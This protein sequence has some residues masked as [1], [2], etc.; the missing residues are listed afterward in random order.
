MLPSILSARRHL[1]Q[2]DQSRASLS[3]PPDS[4][5]TGSSHGTA[6]PR[7]R[8]PSVRSS[9]KRES[10]LSRV[11]SFR[12]SVASPRPPSPPRVE[13]PYSS[14]T[15]SSVTVSTPPLEHQNALVRIG[16]SQQSFSTVSD[17]TVLATPQQ[18]LP[19]PEASPKSSARRKSIISRIFSIRSS[20]R[21]P[22]RSG[23]ESTHVH[24]I[25][26][27]H[28]SHRSS[29]PKPAPRREPTPEV[30]LPTVRVVR[31]KLKRVPKKSPKASVP[32]VIPSRNQH[33]RV[34]LVEP[35][36]S[37]RSQP[38]IVRPS[39]RQQQ[40][41][42]WVQSPP[43]PK[44]HSQPQPKLYPQPQPKLRP[45]PQPQVWPQPEPQ[46]RQ[47][48][49]WEQVPAKPKVRPQPQPLQQPPIQSQKDS[50]Q[51][52]QSNEHYAALRAQ[53]NAA[54]DA[55]GRS[56]D[57]SKQAFQRGDGAMA[58]QLSEEGKAHRAEMERL[59]AEAGAW[60]YGEN[61]K[62]LPP[63]TVDLHGLYVKEAVEYTERAL[64]K[65]REKGATYLRVIVG[66]GIHSTVQ[67]PKIK[68]AIEELMRNQGIEAEFD[69]LN[70][71]VLVVYPEGKDRM[72]QA[73]NSNHS[74]HKPAASRVDTKRRK[75]QT[76]AKARHR[77]SLRRSLYRIS[78]P[79]RPRNTFT[80]PSKHSHSTT[81][82]TR[83]SQPYAKAVQ[84]SD[85]GHPGRPNGNVSYAQRVRA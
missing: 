9:R 12:R 48:P 5:R 17:H 65:A 8:Q 82:N 73:I 43:K 54:G 29:T 46:L 41:N 31:P 64:E 6:R 18:P 14:E 42:A 85:A 40:P 57:A 68:P 76:A 15:P 78:F 32:V 25:P 27:I 77:L 67:G 11:L 83:P 23:I 33:P 16:G 24:E 72:I 55:M 59:H 34:V 44:V 49:V 70:D 47:Q 63:Y 45:Q 3:R 30:P 75:P 74:A 69:P 71:G 61:N 50:N 84:R 1:Q 22:P 53:A 21:T 60:I 7:S 80:T 13:V 56:F 37:R 2:I 35:K 20:S 58:K 62:N 4:D 81:T 66:K 39:T 52:N 28:S 38:V 79:P 19:E 36:S 26:V 10:V 51:A